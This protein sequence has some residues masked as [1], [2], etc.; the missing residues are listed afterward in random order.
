[1]TPLEMP[2]AMISS[3]QPSRPR[4]GRR[5]VRWIKQKL[6]RRAKAEQPPPEKEAPAPVSMAFT[7]AFLDDQGG[8]GGAERR[9]SLYSPEMQL[10]AETNV[11][12]ATPTIA[13]EYVWFNGEPVAQI[14]V[15]TN[16]TKWTLTDHLG[17]PVL[18]T[19]NT[20]AVV[21]RVERE[22]YGETYAIRTGADQHQPLGLPGQEEEQL[23][24]GNTSSSDQRYNIFRWYRAAWGRYTQ[25]DLLHVASSDSNVFRYAINNPVRLADPL[26][27]D[28]RVCC[29]PVKIPLLSGWDHCYI[30]SGNNRPRKTFSLQR[31]AI[32]GLGPI[33]AAAPWPDHPDDKGGVC[34][35]WRPDPCGD[36]ERCLARAS[37]RYPLHRYSDAFANVGI[38]G[39]RNSN[40]FA[41]CVATSC[42]VSAGDRVTGE[43][44]GW[45]QSCPAGF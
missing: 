17:T 14:D 10:L 23:G 2:A 44:P 12:T 34:E 16:T 29:R 25:P 9:Y 4:L 8:G 24:A 38:P 15:A 21:W 39:F 5:M 36:L 42:G 6:T 18:Q 30:E 40:T 13:H 41:K 19:N 33:A 35:S 37:R 22:P 3:A 20:G 28:V 27:L 11:T 7:A 45:T 31:V 32:P 1:M 26:G 43:A